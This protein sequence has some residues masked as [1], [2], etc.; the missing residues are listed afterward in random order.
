MYRS[1]VVL[2]QA[3]SLQARQKPLSF[4]PLFWPPSLDCFASACN[5]S[6]RTSNE[7]GGQARQ[8]VTWNIRWGEPS[9]FDREREAEPEEPTSAAHT[10]A[11]RT[12]PWVEHPSRALVMVKEGYC[13]LLSSGQ[14]TCTWQ[15]GRT[16][17]PFDQGTPGHIKPAVSFRFHFSI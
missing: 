5:R 17:K 11:L 2:C 3:S 7:H 4:R 12:A 9:R 15:R 10:F 13:Q 1:A 16:A 14:S 8:Q 6:R